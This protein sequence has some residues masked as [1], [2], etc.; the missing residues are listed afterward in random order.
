MQE[1]LLAGGDKP[2]DYSHL[3]AQANMLVEAEQSFLQLWTKCAYLKNSGRC[4][5]FFHDLIK[6]NNKRNTIVAIMKTSSEHAISI[7]D[8]AAEF[9]AYYRNL[10]ETKV[11]CDDL[12]ISKLRSCLVL[13]DV[14]QF[15]LWLWKRLERCCLILVM[16]GLRVWIAEEQ[17]SSRRH[18]ILWD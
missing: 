3:Y 10:L 4:M 12:D 9:V 6:W 5:K 8:V 16:T 18:E 17:K 11:H 15:N 1:E 13:S 2:S 14:Q 7:S